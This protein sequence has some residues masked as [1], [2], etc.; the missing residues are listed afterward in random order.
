MK[1]LIRERIKNNRCML[2][3]WEV[4]RLSNLI[5]DQ[6]KR[7]PEFISAK[8]ILFYM[9]I[10]NE[11]DIFPL[12]RESLSDKKIFL[13]VTDTKRRKLIIS[14]IKNL[15]NLKLGAYGIFEPAEIIDTDLKDIDLAI[16]P[17]LAFDRTGRR[18]GYGKGYYD[19]LLKKTRIKKIGLGFE[20]QIEDSLPSEKH[21]VRLDMIITEERMIDCNDSKNN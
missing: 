21:D 9:P 6:L 8:N 3:S 11:V 19:R 5:I 1:Q 18:I 4:N 13:P 15:G 14:E 2:V 10:K 17:G 12:I 20:F 7:L 16:I